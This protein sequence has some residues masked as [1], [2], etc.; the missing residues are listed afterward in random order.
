MLKQQ[1]YLSAMGYLAGKTIDRGS[2]LELK[3]ASAAKKKMKILA[4]HQYDKLVKIDFGT[5]SPEEMQQLLTK[6]ISNKKKTEKIKQLE[7][8]ILEA[9]TSA[10]K[11]KK[12]HELFELINGVAYKCT[13]ENKEEVQKE[14]CKGMK[15]TSDGLL[16]TNKPFRNSSELRAQM[17]PELQKKITEVRKKAEEAENKK[18]RENEKS[19]NERS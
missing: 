8:E 9:K 15:Q 1:D 2:E 19:K 17:T 14:S 3:I 4:S 16:Y 6:R 18:K 5:I 7:K 12:T 13:E 10:E 11:L